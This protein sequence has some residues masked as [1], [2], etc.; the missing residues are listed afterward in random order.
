MNQRITKE[1]QLIIKEKFPKF[2]KVT[3]CMCNNPEYGV[4]LSPAAKRLLRNAGSKAK[5]RNKNVASVRLTSDEMKWIESHGKSFS[6]IVHE[7]IKEKMI[8]DCS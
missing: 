7:V 2:S 6:E 1:D 8:D 3:A 4:T 5:P